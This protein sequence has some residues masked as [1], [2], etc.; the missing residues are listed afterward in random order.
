MKRIFF[1]LFGFLLAFMISTSL[2]AQISAPGSGGSDETNYT[3]FPETDSIFIFCTTSDIDEVGRLQ[4]FTDLVGTKTFLWEKYNSTT[5]DFEFYF[6]ES[7]DANNSEISGLADGGYRI[8]ITQGG[9]TEIN[10]AWVFNNWTI[11]DGSV[12]ES[13]CELFQLT[14]EFTTAEL[15][16]YDLMDNTELL[17]SKN[18]KV[19][20]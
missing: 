11:A 19:Q 8:T 15:K 18:I 6:S 2:Q 13:N 1:Y 12:T 17:V 7:S 10:R 9:T 5:A 16:Y 14:G 20:W 4:I 3:T